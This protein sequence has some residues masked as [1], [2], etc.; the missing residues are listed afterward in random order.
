MSVTTDRGELPCSQRP[1]HQSGTHR[2]SPAQT[3]TNR[4][5]SS[6][7]RWARGR[8]RPTVGRPR[9]DTQKLDRATFMTASTLSDSTKPSTGLSARRP[10][11]LLPCPD[12]ETRS[13]EKVPKEQ[14][15]P[16]AA[17][18]QQGQHRRPDGGSRRPRTPGG[19]N[20]ST[21]TTAHGRE[22]RRRG[23]RVCGGG[24]ARLRWGGGSIQA[25]SSGGRGLHCDPVANQSP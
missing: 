18:P 12:T 24:G 3:R 7:E 14:N 10:W 25:S 21:R 4:A 11:G 19:T 2:T 6:G 17:H 16:T 22:G 1:G 15:P 9:A 8:L 23:G 13:A 5:A 20:H